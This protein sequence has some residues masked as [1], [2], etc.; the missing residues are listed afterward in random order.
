MV[1]LFFFL[2]GEF[3]R[4]DLRGLQENLTRRLALVV[5]LWAPDG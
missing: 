5:A 3:S 4:P 2:W 1:F